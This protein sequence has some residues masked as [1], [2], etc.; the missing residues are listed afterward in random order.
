MQVTG[1]VSSGLGEGAFFTALKWVREQSKKLLGFEPFPGTLN[2]ELAA[3]EAEYL[4]NYLREQDGIMLRSPDERF[5][6][7]CCY[8]LLV[9]DSIRGAL[10]IPE[11]TAHPRSCLEIIAPVMLKQELQ[12][13]DGD[14]VSL[15]LE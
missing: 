4:R 14:S 6:N 15:T 13:R 7:A 11:V 9:N 2:V 5:C 3:G 8:S 1:K 12:L 10:V